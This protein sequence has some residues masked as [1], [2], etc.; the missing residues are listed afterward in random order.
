MT[1]LS[2]DTMPFL[3]SSQSPW[4]TRR[5]RKAVSTGH[6]CELAAGVEIYRDLSR[7][8]KDM[9]GKFKV[10]E[11]QCQEVGRELLPQDGGNGGQWVQIA[12]PRK[13][14]LLGCVHG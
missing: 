7:K 9:D 1:S 12:D 5:K 14:P 2:L 8:T 11:R 13:Y 10:Q 3:Q 6:S 4:H